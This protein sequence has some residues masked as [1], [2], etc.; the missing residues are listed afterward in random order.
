MIQR[1]MR[2][3]M[4]SDSASV[5]VNADGRIYIGSITVN[6]EELDKYLSEVAEA[7]TI[8]LGQKEVA[9]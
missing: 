4:E 1:T 3:V 5:A 8:L 7:A 6:V 9:K 2:V